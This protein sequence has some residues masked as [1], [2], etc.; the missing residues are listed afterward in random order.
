MVKRAT[1]ADLAREAGVSVATVDRV[2]NRRLPVREDTA[3]QVIEAAERIGYHATV[4]LKQRIRET[5]PM[6]FGFLLQKHDDFYS[7]LGTAMAEATRAH[8]SVR[9]RPIV[10][11][12]EEIIPSVIAGRVLDLAGRC[13]ALTV[14]ALDHPAVNA[15]VE[16]VSAMGKPVFALISDI[17]ASSRAGCLCV[18]RQRSG[19]IA[20]WAISRLADGPGTVGTLVGSHRYLSQEVAVKSFNAYMNEH[21]PQFR[22]LEPVINLDDTHIAHAAVVELLTDNPDLVGLHVAGGGMQGLV[23]AL[24]EERPGGKVISVCNELT[25]ATRS[26][27]MDGTIHIVLDTPIAQLAAETVKA[28]ARRVLDPGTAPILVEV[29]PTIH[30]SAS[31]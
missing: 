18:D 12:N 11:F 8:L 20:G 29:P 1:I 2:L 26:G 24:R 23:E 13:D 3:Q 5:P 4:L 25:P 7:A 27:L 9:G 22:L 17:A 6:T 10:E 15:A 16:E 19:R 14:V 31:I 30:I 21:A 28:M